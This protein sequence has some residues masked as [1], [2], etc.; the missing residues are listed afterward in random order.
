MRRRVGVVAA[1]VVAVTALTG[2][3]QAGAAA[4]CQKYEIRPDGAASAS[5]RDNPS[6]GDLINAVAALVNGEL[7]LP[8]PAVSNAHVCA[9]EAALTEEILRNLGAGGL[10]A[11]GSVSRALGIATRVGIFLRGDYLGRADLAGRIAVVAHELAHVS[12][13][14]LARGGQ[15][16]VPSWISEGHAE[17]VAFRVLDR[18]GVRAYAASRERVVDSLVAS[19]TPITLFPELSD[20]TA[21]TLG[22]R[23]VELGHAATY[24]QAFLAVDWLVDQYGS[25]SLVDYLGRFERAADPGDPWDAVFG[26]SYGEFV[27]DFRDHL[28]RL[29]PAHGVDDARAMAGH[30]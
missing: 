21:Q 3:G 23:W 27:A 28:K 30:S 24:G 20:L 12:Q 29:V 13:A 26:I 6:D 9:D 18:L 11:W 25:A 17:W 15:R 14:Q 5:L 16:D 7:G 8:L 10:R 2:S 1:L 22:T 4:P 19:R